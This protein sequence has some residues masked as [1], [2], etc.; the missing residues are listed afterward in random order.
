MKKRAKKYVIYFFVLIFAATFCFSA[1]KIISYF[2]TGQ[3]EQSEFEKLAQSAQI[4][5]TQDAPK[6]E[7]E[8]ETPAVQQS[9]E[10]DV[11]A[12]KKQNKHCIGW[13]SV[14]GTNINYPVMHTPQD[15]EYYLRR[16]F[17]GKYS[18]SGVPFMDYRCNLEGEHLIIYG[19]NMM[20][21]TMF[22]DLK[23]FL[24]ESYRKEHSEI[25]LK[26]EDGRLVYEILQV[27]KVSDRDI[28]YSN[29]HPNDG[30]QYLTLSTCYG[31]VDERL[32]VIAIKK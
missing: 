31:D 8:P 26:T 14:A 13:L 20:N 32:V 11:A 7:N 15:P 6:T 9:F 17:S 29:L 10:I 18:R 12:L 21:G 24:K 16:N 2:V 28:W 25:I 3:Q 23:K 30:K 19:H 4:D 5:N 27:K 22:S 1:Y